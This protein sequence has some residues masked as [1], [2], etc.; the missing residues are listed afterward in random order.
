MSVLLFC[1]AGPRPLFRALHQTR[2]DWVL[3]DVP[4]NS[5]KLV[6]APDGVIKGFFLPEGFS[7]STQNPICLIRRIP[8]NC[9]GDYWQKPF[10]PY[11]NV[12]VIG[13]HCIGTQPIQLLLFSAVMESIR[14]Y[15][16]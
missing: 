8:F 1:G 13:H 15:L 12:Y 4:L 5:I 9:L 2:L 3:F 6:F 10:R 11:E 16:G 7:G 14:Y